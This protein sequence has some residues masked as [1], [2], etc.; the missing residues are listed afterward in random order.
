M[1]ASFACDRP[2]HAAKA[3]RS[4]N[5]GLRTAPRLDRLGAVLRAACAV[6]IGAVCLL[7]PEGA[8]AQRQ[9]GIQLGFDDTTIMVSKDISNAR[10]AISYDPDFGVVEGNVFPQD[11]SAPQ[12]VWCEDTGGG[13][14]ET[15]QF[16]CFGAGPCTVGP[17]GTDGDAWTFIATV[18]LEASFFA[19]PA[20]G[21][22][23][24]SSVRPP[25][26]P[27]RHARRK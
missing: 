8:L 12:F 19:L 22:A 21:A 2:S 15:L 11:G 26:P 14:D 27:R 23:S 5:P 16:D 1:A 9:S 6:A 3:S 13:T 18:P 20:D 17:C 7:A 4:A 25:P 10:W 24:A